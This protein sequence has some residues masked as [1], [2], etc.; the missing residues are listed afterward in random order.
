M[1]HFLKLHTRSVFLLWCNSSDVYSHCFKSAVFK[2][3]TEPGNGS[4]LSC[5]ARKP[6]LIK[7]QLFF[8]INNLL[9]RYYKKNYKAILIRKLPLNIL[10]NSNQKFKDSGKL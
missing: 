4:S 8:G 7:V 5:N 2:A 1:G 3:I 10:I 9:S 6:I